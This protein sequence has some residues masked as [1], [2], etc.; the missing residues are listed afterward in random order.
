MEIR[1][2]T[3]QL[4]A[5]SPHKLWSIPTGFAA[6]LAAATP[7]LRIVQS[8]DRESFLRLL[9]EATILFT[10]SLPQRHFATA[11]RL[12]W[13]HSPW[14]GVD[15]FLYPELVA[16]PVVLT[17]SKGLS[18]DALADHAMGMILSWSRRLA[19]CR[20]LQRRREWNPETFWDSERPPFALAGKTLLVLGLGGIGLGVARRAVAAGL[21]VLAVRRQRA[22]GAPGEVV[23]VHGPEALD[24]LLPRAD[25]VV[26][27]LPGTPETR[28]IIGEARLRLFRP[29]ALLVNVGRG[30]LVDEAALVAALREGRLG[31]AALD[32]VAEEPLP[33]A[34]PLWDDPRVIISPHIAGTEPGHMAR[35]AEL[36]AENLRRF[37][38]DQPLLNVVDKRA[39]Y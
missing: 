19:D 4:N 9:P 3:V 7:G 2:V 25:V 21:R 37:L 10:W 17:C 26:L 24:S 38:T 28:G 16:S 34:S 29:G 27:A 32:V 13:I 39:G 6:R 36:F 5:F 8:E 11:Q 23:E 14:A 35:A 30:D 22:D 20:D 33:P 18:A 31:G 12:R 15:D 1:D